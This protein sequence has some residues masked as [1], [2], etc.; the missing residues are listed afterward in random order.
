MDDMPPNLIPQYN[1][2]FLQL[3]W[4][5]FFSMTFP[6][7]ALFTILAG[8]L[9]MAIELK[10]MS[11][12]K[13]K[14]EPAMIKDLG[15]WIDILEIIGWLGIGICMYLIMFTSKK[16]DTIFDVDEHIMFYVAFG[17]L[18]VIMMT[19]YVLQEIIEDEPEWVVEDRENTEQRVKQVLED[20]KDKKLIERMQDHYTKTDVLFEVLDMQHSNL[21]Y[22]SQLVPII[23]KGCRAWLLRNAQEN[24]KSEERERNAQKAAEK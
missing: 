13:K 2:L 22:S 23:Q 17:F 8:N 24:A 16:L 14:N 20:N 3:G 18:H 9:R 6:A 21:E 10:G 7:G 11:E 5:L 15:I 19:K 12:Y 1:E 4:I